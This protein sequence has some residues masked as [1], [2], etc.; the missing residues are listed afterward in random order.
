MKTY[1]PISVLL[2]CCFFC[3]KPAFN[4]SVEGI[5]IQATLGATVRV[6]DLEQD[7]REIQSRFK[8]PNKEW[9]VP[10]WGVDEN[11]IIYKQAA[12]DMVR[13]R[14]LREVSPAPDTSF[15]AVPDNGNSIPPDVGGAAGP[16]HLMTTLNTQVRIHDRVGTNLFSVSLATFWSALPGASDTF[17]PKVVYDPYENRWIMTTPSSSNIGQTRVYIGV[18]VTDDPMGAWHMYWIDPDPNDQ[19]WFDYPNLGF[20]KNWISV[21]GIMRGGSD[22][23]YVVFAMDKMAA[24]NGEASPMVHRFTYNDGSALV[25]AYTYD[26]D[27]ED[28]YYVSTAD[29]NTNGYGY[30]NKFKLSGSISNPVFEFEG[31]IGVEDPWEN[32]SYDNNGDF[33]PQLGSTQKLNSVDARMHTLIYRNNKLW[34]V[35]HIYLPADNPQRSAIQWWELDTDGSILQRG[36]VDDPSNEFSFAFSSIAVNANEDILIGHGIFSENQYAG[37][38]YSFK[39]YLDDPNTIRTYY[40][41]KEGLAP[42]YKTFGGSRNRWGDYSTACVDPVNDYDFWALQEY[43][44]LPSGGDQWGTWW[45]YVRP[46]FPPIADFS[47]NVSLL[48]VGESVDFS[49]LSYGIP[50]AWAWTFEG[51]TPASSTEQNPPAV[52]YDQEGSFDVSLIATN[53]LG[54]DTIIKT[55]FITTSTTIL[56]LIDFSTDKEMACVGEVVSF[57]DLSLYM[58]HSWEWQFDPSTVAFTNGTSQN[59]QHPQLIFEEATTYAATLTAWNLNGQ[60][61]LTKFD[62]INAGGYIP[63]F[64]EDFENEDFDI[65]FWTVENPDDDKGWEL[66][67]VGG[68]MPGNW[69]AGVNIRDYYNVGERDRL[70]S[71]PFNLENLNTAYLGFQYAYAQ[72]FAPISDSLIV[73][74]SGDCGASWTRVFAGGDDGSGNFATHEL[75]DNFWPEVEADW[76]M[77]GWGA[78]CPSIDL[79]AWAGSPNVQIAFETYCFQ[80]NALFIDNVTISQ[81]VGTAETLRPLDA[82]HIYP[83]PNNGSLTVLFPD[84]PAY[85]HIEIMDQYGKVIERRP[86]DGFSGKLEMNLSG[87]IP[88]GLYILKI[89]GSAQPLS[90]KIMVRQN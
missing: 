76:C 86:L 21:G 33:L 6:S 28:L 20:N 54:T 26:P 11:R 43:A 51:G 45:A 53:S 72:R 57:T 12:S 30:I 59:S 71:P 62:C 56:P 40:Q 47:S 66:F 10:D 65:H 24:Y 83:N 4:Q 58:P 17:D 39:S 15:A 89:V 88:A 79:T 1:P 32:W 9:E 14:V 16:N 50:T 46:S 19:K 2:L 52:M 80:G 31:A 61:T 67:E 87:K 64:K 63:W 73:Y 37:A 77:E 68:S 69:A 42:Y 36:R 81:S 85:S 25:P 29:G 7:H 60:S 90:K 8:A 38:G 49:D 22:I 35:H 13:G 78:A 84:D 70:I 3:T 23:Y 55:D 5:K 27:M 75:T 48:P 34:A 82:L 18:S 44:E 41:Y 74:I